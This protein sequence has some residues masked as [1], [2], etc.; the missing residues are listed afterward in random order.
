MSRRL[1][2]DALLTDAQG[3]ALVSDPGSIAWLC[4]PH[5]DPGVSCAGLLGGVEH[6]RWQLAPSEEVRATRR[7]YRDESLVL[8]TD[9]ET[10]AGSIRLV[11][12]VPPRT[13]A[14]ALV[15]LVEGV[16]GRVRMRMD[17]RAR[18]DGGSVDGVQ[19]AAGSDG[20]QLRAPVETHREGVAVRADFVV[21]AGELLPFVLEW[22]PSHDDAPAP[23]DPLRALAD[24]EAYWAERAVSRAATQHG[25]GAPAA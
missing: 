1:E 24:T 19:A 10:A 7:R 9:F 2:G 16:R 12:F 6:G 4:P 23:L 14:A 22:A 8:E 18:S 13:R 11:E 15:R 21:T 17:L 25:P 3:V 20:L 5:C